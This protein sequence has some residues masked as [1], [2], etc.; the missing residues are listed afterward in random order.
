[1]RDCP[2]EMVTET[3]PISRSKYPFAAMKV[4]GE[5]YKETL[6]GKQPGAIR[7]AIEKTKRMIL[8]ELNERWRFTT[9]VDTAEDG[10]KTITVWRIR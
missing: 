1:M 9:W 3:K 5:A 4:G 10:V 7:S 2:G 8:K 6:H